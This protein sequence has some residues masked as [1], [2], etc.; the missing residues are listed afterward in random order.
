MSRLVWAPRSRLDLLRLHTFLAAKNTEA[1]SRAIKTLR[2]GLKILEKYPEIGRPVPEYSEEYREWVIE[3]GQAAYVALYHYN[4]KQVT[5]LAL[6]HG[7][8]AGY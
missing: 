5:I 6:R 8:E 4:G 7:R 3:F 1:A 2:Q